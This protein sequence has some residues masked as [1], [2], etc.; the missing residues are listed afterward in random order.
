MKEKHRSILEA[1]VAGL[2]SNDG[3]MSWVKTID[4]YDKCMRSLNCSSLS[5]QP[6]GERLESLEFVKHTGATKL[7]WNVTSKETKTMKF[8]VPIEEPKHDKLSLM[9]DEY[10]EGKVSCI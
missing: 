6:A 9:W 1:V 5:R 7:G 10:K 8:D 2:A 3:P 4:S